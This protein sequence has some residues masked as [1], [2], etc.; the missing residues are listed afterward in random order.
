MVT[1]VVRRRPRRM[2]RLALFL[3]LSILVTLINTGIL[4]FRQN[5][6][7]KQTQP[8][9]FTRPNEQS[10]NHRSNVNMPADGEVHIPKVIK[11]DW[12]G[13]EWQHE[14]CIPFDKWQLM[15]YGPS[16]CNVMHE[17][18][19]AQPGAL[20]FINCGTSRCAFSIM[21][22][23]D[24]KVILKWT[25]LRSY[26]KPGKLEAAWK[27]TIAMERLQGSKYILNIYGNCGSSQMVE[28]AGG[29]ALYDQMVVAK[30]TENAPDGLL[31]DAE[32][33]LRVS[34]HVARAVADLHSIDGTDAT[35]FIHDDICCDQYLFVDGVFKLN[36]FNRAQ[37]QLRNQTSGLGCKD[38]VS[39]F[40]IG[41]SIG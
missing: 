27:D 38:N 15:E 10:Q 28:V 11:P 32:T 37:T 17:M 36:D 25:K 22:E 3:A 13:E 23:L 20:S 30:N 21:N 40:Y 2:S 9:L 35:S 26:E 24:E 39:D 33:N 31:N 18:D 1:V 19:I 16:S 6:G 5:N 4:S 34:Y 41:V 7:L 29:G 14:E 8:F 12:L